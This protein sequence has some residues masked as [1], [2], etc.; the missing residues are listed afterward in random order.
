MSEAI[1]LQIFPQRTVLFLGHYCKLDVT[2]FMDGN[3]GGK[4]GLLI[5][6][7][8]YF[9]WLCWYTSR[10]E[11]RQ[12]GTDVGLDR[13]RLFGAVRGRESPAGRKTKLYKTEPIREDMYIFTLS[14]M[15]DFSRALLHLGG[16]INTHDRY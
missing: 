13:Q 12:C 5:P 4:V 8:S 3:A 10:L 15:L 2:K 7:P 9:S 1:K 14:L 16:V 11:P 6:K